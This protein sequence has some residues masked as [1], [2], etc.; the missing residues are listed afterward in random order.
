MKVTITQCTKPDT[1][2]HV[3]MGNWAYPDYDFGFHPIK[4]AR[5]IKHLVEIGDLKAAI[6]RAYDDYS[7]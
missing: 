4:T 1:L 5:K 2:Y 7:M 3:Y 6:E